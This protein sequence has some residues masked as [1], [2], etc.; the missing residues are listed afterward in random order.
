MSEAY[1]VLGEDGEYSGYGMWLVCAYT[2]EALAR[3]HVK[4][5]TALQAE[6]VKAREILGLSEWEIT[7]ATRT[8]YSARA[9]DDQFSE[10][11]SYT[12]QTVPLNEAVPNMEADTNPAQTR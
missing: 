5:M 2:D 12:V 9:G 1:I 10:S 8:A 3:E 6:L 7:E 11:V 4:R